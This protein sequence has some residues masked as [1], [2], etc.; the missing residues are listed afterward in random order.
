MQV[1]SITCLKFDPIMRSKYK[2]GLSVQKTLNKR[3]RTCCVLII[4]IFAAI[5]DIS[6]QTPIQVG[7]TIEGQTI[8]VSGNI[9]EV[10]ST[11]S[12]P[13]GSHLI[14]EPGTV[15]RFNRH[16]GIDVF[17]QLSAIGSQNDSIRF[18]PNHQSLN[19]HWKWEGIRFVSKTNSDTSII[20]HAKISLA[21]FSITVNSINGNVVIENSTIRD[22]ENHSISIEAS[23]LI[24]VRNNR[25]FEKT[26]S[27]LTPRSVAVKIINSQ[28]C[29]IANN[30]IYNNS[31]A[32]WLIANGF[33][34]ESRN[35]IIAGNNISDNFYESILINNENGGVCVDNMII[36]NY[37]NSKFVGIQIGS[38][39]SQGT[40]RNVIRG[41]VII[42]DYQR[43]LDIYNDSTVIEH[44]LIMGNSSA[45]LI[46][47]SANCLIR[48]NHIHYNIGG[49]LIGEGSLNTVVE[50][51]TFSRNESQLILIGE[52]S[53]TLIRRN[54]F[55]D[56]L[57]NLNLIRNTTPNDLS[58]HQNYWGSDS[59]EIIAGMI[60][61][62]IDDANLG[63][64]NFQ[65]FLPE[66]D[67]VAP[68]SAPW[69]VFKQY[70]GNQLRVFWDPNPEN[71]VRGYAV[72][73][74]VMSG[75]T[76]PVARD[77]GDA[78]LFE[79]ETLTI[80]DTIAVTA[81]DTDSLILASPAYGHLSPHSFAVWVPYAG[82]DTTVC[83]NAG[84]ILLSMSTAFDYDSL[85][86]ETGGDGSFNNINMLWP[87]Y[88]PGTA[89][90]TS[91]KVELS[92][93][94]IR[95]NEYFSDHLIL[96][97]I[98][99]A[100]VNAGADTIVSP[101]ETLWITQARASNY[102][103]LR[104]VTTGDG[105]FN[106]AD[107]LHPA[108]TPGNADRLNGLVQLVLIAGSECGEVSDT[109]QVQIR[110]RYNI[111]G[112]VWYRGTGAHGGVVLAA[113][114]G[115]YDLRIAKFASI[116]DN[117]IFK[118]SYLEPGNYFLY[119]V[120]DTSGWFD[121]APGYYVNRLRWQDAY[122]L[123]LSADVYDVDIF[124][125]E[126]DAELNNGNGSISG[127]FALP[128]LDMFD[129][130][131]YCVSWFDDEITSNN[132]CK[133]GLPNVSILL[134]NST[135]QALLGSTITDRDGQFRFNHLP[136]GS[137]II[138]A[139][140]AGY[141]TIPSQVLTLTPQNP[142]IQDIVLTI[143]PM[144]TITVKGGNNTQPLPARVAA[145][146]VPAIDLIRIASSLPVGGIIEF[147]I[148][149]ITGQVV[150]Q[151]KKTLQHGLG[152]SGIEIDIS[153]LEPGFYNGIV[154][155]GT[156]MEWFT[157]IKK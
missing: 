141:S 135:K 39:T 7:G 84:E 12:V 31:G 76:F 8:W 22:S 48:N 118:L 30:Q 62:G 51:N 114:Q 74:G 5:T 113:A 106:N 21:R 55:L 63:V 61:D 2:T 125:H 49:I 77:I 105:S 92:L 145:Y 132:F 38:S 140:V 35:N 148:R 24:T 136:Y 80:Y 126:F 20:S 122:L 101:G 82:R 120:P 59:V 44:N 9:Y 157:F 79:S 129:T 29:I 60:Y 142:Q 72:F 81:Y 6:G 45:I 16:T 78:T 18:K 50:L 86:W 47:L 147:E 19:Q 100:F 152:L 110:D 14:I 97:F 109:L 121:G 65:P 112:K 153:G 23:N 57:S 154:K 32:I 70:T 119:A 93:H 43:G 156:G 33:A 130:T 15:I 28:S 149:N 150:L 99:P 67:T 73:S 54:N 134:F 102:D 53:G 88:Y 94:T 3:K 151:G 85:Y 36:D 4:L 90:I 91:G 34:R 117:G 133:D 128:A 155:S 89:D 137:Y 11:V 10:I 143:T 75:Y 87:I 25:I 98:E 108:Y 83:K 26:G 66:P 1:L 123:N 95:K 37:I 42:S 41:N 144:K 68:I 139:E 116:N 13:A 96:Y 104:W 107:T 27:L 115:L 111:H 71:D 127:Y 146:P 131:I 69:P 56:N 46:N 58:V 103:Y 138:D 52:T 124:L 17:G 40:R 64:L